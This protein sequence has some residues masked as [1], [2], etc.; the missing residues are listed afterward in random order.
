MTIRVAQWTTGRIASAAVRAVIAHPQL[1]LVGCYAWSA[2]KAGKDL[3]ELVDLP[4]LGVT[5]TSD[6]DELLAANPDVVLYMPLLWNV[7]DMVRLLEAGVNVISTA[8]FLTGRSYGEADMNRLH[9]AAEAGGASL[10]GAG[11]NPGLVSA[12]ALTAAA[13]CRRVKRISIHEAADCTSYES[14]E[15]WQALGFG[16]PPDTPNLADAAKQRQLVFMDA[17]EMM[18]DALHVEL[19]EIRYSPEFGLATKDLDLGYMRIPEG[20]VCGL[21]GLWQGMVGGEPFIEMGLTWR[22]G[23]SM[24][25]DWPIEEGHIMEI[26]AEP[27]IR[28]RFQ[29]EFAADFSDFGG[30]TAN[31]AVNAIPAVVAARPGLVTVADLPLVTAGSIAALDS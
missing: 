25:P 15:T 30:E 10:Y 5:A 9:R 27:T 3:G 17:V 16:S 12:V 1:E 21:R 7:D 13:A 2:E 29:I 28:V 23:N 31:P 22:L 20:H 14:A 6:I 8:N 24:E 26:V 19:D 18:A 11:I 4:P